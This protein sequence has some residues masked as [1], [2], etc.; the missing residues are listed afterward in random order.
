MEEVR[1][2]IKESLNGNENY[3]ALAKVTASK[4]QDSNLEMIKY[5]TVDDEVPGVYV[6]LNKPFSVMQ[7]FLVK[8][9]INTD[10]IIFIDAVTKTSGGDVKKTEK[11]LFIGSPDNLS[12]ISLAMDQ[13]VRAVPGDKKFL[14]FDSLDTLLVYNKPTTVAK[15][16]HFLSGKMRVWNVKGIIVS[17]EKDSNKELLDELS[18]FCD[19]LLEL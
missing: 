15:F 17:L 1:N 18:Q 13:A 14:F 5:L 16:I 19:I 2:K 4:Y 9:G 10:M 3:V 7:P 6:T 11:C 12:D 8:K